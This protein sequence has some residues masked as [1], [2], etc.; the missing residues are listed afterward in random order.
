GRGRARRR[1][2]PHRR[3]LHPRAGAARPAPPH[4]PRGPPPDRMDQHLGGAPMSRF[5]DAFG[6]WTPRAVVFDCDGLLL[7]TESV[8]QET[9]DKVVARSEE[10]TSELQS[11]ENL[12]CRLL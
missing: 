2:A 12:V 10:H 5:T 9:E 6:D 4:Y 3:P 7:D 8:W 1:P 11:R